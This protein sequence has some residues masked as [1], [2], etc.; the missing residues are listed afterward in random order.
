MSVYCKYS[1]YLCYNY[2][3]TATN[4]QPYCGGTAPFTCGAR[5]PVTPCWLRP[6]PHLPC[7]SGDEWLYI[8]RQAYGICHS[9]D[10]HKFGIFEF[11]LCTAPKALPYCDYSKFSM[12]LNLTL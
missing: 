7:P 11:T 4:H 5:P 12:F 8:R 6:C 1:Y 2:L 10:L 3:N 9:R